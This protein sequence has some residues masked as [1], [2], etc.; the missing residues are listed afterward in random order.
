MLSLSW[1]KIAFPSCI[2]TDESLLKKGKGTSFETSV[3]LC[4]VSRTVENAKVVC[5][6][7][8]NIAID[9]MNMFSFVQRP[10]E[11][12][13]SCVS[14]FGSRGCVPFKLNPLVFSGIVQKRASLNTKHLRYRLNRAVTIAICPFHFLEDIIGYFLAIGAVGLSSLLCGA[15]IGTTRRFYCLKPIFPDFK[16]L[17]TE[18]AFSFHDN[19]L[20]VGVS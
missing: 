2:K 17:P 19:I 14:I 16:R 1:D 20:A 15:G 6:V 9:M 7:I 12:C 11:R 3:T 18:R 10:T 5:G 4:M 13:H 8:R